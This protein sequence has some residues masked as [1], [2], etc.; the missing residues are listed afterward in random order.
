MKGQEKIEKGKNTTKTNGLK[1]TL[2]MLQVKTVGCGSNFYFRLCV[3]Y[4]MSPRW[5]NICKYMC[6]VS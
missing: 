6:P 5:L 2:K 1:V 3:N 4:F